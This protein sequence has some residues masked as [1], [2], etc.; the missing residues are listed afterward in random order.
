MKNYKEFMKINNNGIIST[1]DKLLRINGF[2]NAVNL[3]IEHFICCK[4]NKGSKN[5]NN[6]SFLFESENGQNNLINNKN[7]TDK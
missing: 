2:I 1:N 5:M 7:N 4:Y 6:S 3:G